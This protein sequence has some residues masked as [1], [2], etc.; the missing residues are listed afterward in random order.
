MLCALMLLAVLPAVVVLALRTKPTTTTASIGSS[1]RQRSFTSPNPNVAFV[2]S[3]AIPRGGAD[4]DADNKGGVEVDNEDETEAT[5]EE[6]D[7]EEEEA[8]IDDEEDDEEV[9]VV[10]VEEEEQAIVAVDEISEEKGD[11]EEVEEIE[12]ELIVEEVVEEVVEEPTVEEIID[13]EE[14]VEEE[15]EEDEEAVLED[16]EEEV[17]FPEEIPSDDVRAF[18]TTDGELADDEG[19]YTDGSGSSNMFPAGEEVELASASASATVE[20]EAQDENESPVNE[21]EEPAT[22]EAATE[23]EDGG[24]GDDDNDDDSDGDE[25]PVMITAAT[26]VPPEQIQIESI[27]DDALKSLLMT[28][29]RYTEQDVDQMR[30]EIAQQVAYHKLARPTEGMPKNWY[31]EGFEP[32]SRGSLLSSSLMKGKK[33]KNVVISIAAAVGVTALSIGVMRDDSDLGFDGIKDALQ[34]IPKAI[35]AMVVAKSS[36]AKISST[37]AVAAAAPVAVAVAVETIIAEEEDDDKVPIEGDDSTTVDGKIHSIKPGTTPKEVPNPD[38]DL[39]WLD[40]LLTNIERSMKSFF[41][42]KI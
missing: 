18:H 14:V 20:V 13:V 10:A 22:V 36:S 27:I 19:M 12:V 24:D 2:I 39:T 42:M 31:V 3:H 41:N 15:V 29:L 17:V 4:G 7:E 11:T 6:E 30:P 26:E 25:D 9:V 38:D 32:N 1:Y 5:T 16:E 40:K 33:K 37:P 8:T 28:D 23:P 21:D 35:A 34:G